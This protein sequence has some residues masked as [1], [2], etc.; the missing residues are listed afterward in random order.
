[1]C[2]L[3]CACSEPSHDLLV[4]LNTDLRPRLD[5]EHVRTSILEAPTRT[6]A[7]EHD[8]FVPAVDDDF[9]TFP[10]RRV[11]ELL[12][13][14]PG[15]YVIRLRLLDIGGMDVA[16]RDLRVD[17]TS[18]RVV[19]IR[20]T[21]DCLGVECP[22]VGD[23]ADRTE[24][25]GG[26]CVPPGCTADDIELCGTGCTEEAQCTAAVS[27]ARGSCVMGECLSSPDDALCGP[28]E[29]C[30]IMDGCAVRPVIPVDA[31]FD[32]GVDAGPGADGGPSC[33]PAMCN[34]G[35]PCTDD[36]CMGGRCVNN[37]RCDFG[38]YCRAGVCEPNPTFRLETTEA[39][40]CADIGVPHLSGADF[41]FRRTVTGRAN[42]DAQQYNQQVSC[43]TAVETAGV[44]RLDAAGREQAP[45]YT[46]PPTPMECWDGVYGRWNAW[47]GVDGMSSNVEEVTYYDSRCSNVRTC[48]MA[49]TFCSPCRGC[50]L[51]TGYC[52]SGTTCA[53]DPTLAITAS[54]GAGCVDL[55]VPHTGPPALSFVITGRPSSTSTQINQHVSCGGPEMD[56]DVRPLSAA[57]R[58]TDALII[59]AAACDI[60]VYGLWNVTVRID[61]ER[62]NVVPIVYYNS[63]CA[64]AFSTCAA[65]RSYCPPGG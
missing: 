31:G 60:T 2:L 3:L 49:R 30:D 55:A 57:G 8:D 7:G 17:L 28:E 24:C 50:D 15:V 23:P 53:P 34:D 59:G 6:L 38:Q 56:A 12:N 33:V 29:Y 37:P 10:G 47:V 44:H 20:I 13:Y 26:R 25:L 63:A 46:V 32:S 18:S 9:L 43:G 5:F 61:G 51:S 4:D 36:T 35:D 22:G 41:L 48:A 40:G 21:S 58:A 1:M 64:P 16:A 65:A 39:G 62:S 11:A 54:E 52:Y 42:A 27:C 14:P 19:R 45:F